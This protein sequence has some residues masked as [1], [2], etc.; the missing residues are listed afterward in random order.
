MRNDA[1]DKG[2]DVIVTDARSESR[3][4]RYRLLGPLE[5]L[6]GVFLGLLF[7]IIRWWFLEHLGLH[8]DS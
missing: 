3:H 6:L 4:G 7:L 5:N 1:V 2:A 8:C